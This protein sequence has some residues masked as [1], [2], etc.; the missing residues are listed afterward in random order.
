[1][2]MYAL[3][4]QERAKHDPAE[5]DATLDKL[6]SSRCEIHPLFLFTAVLQAYRILHGVNDDDTYADAYQFYE[7]LRDVPPGTYSIPLDARDRLIG[8]IAV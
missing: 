4:K 7:G 2:N 1:M 8:N 5:L 3:G 6:E